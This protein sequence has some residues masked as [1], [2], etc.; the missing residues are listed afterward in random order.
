MYVNRN[1]KP[2]EIL[3]DAEVV[4]PPADVTE[5]IGAERAAA[6]VDG[7]VRLTE[8]RRDRIGAIFVGRELRKLGAIEPRRHAGIRWEAHVIELDLIESAVDC[9]F[10]Q[11]CV[12]YAKIRIQFGRALCF[13]FGWK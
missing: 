8:E 6:L 13:G 11:R 5:D 10:R 7:G 1:C 3:A 9:L 12:L 4:I 2:F